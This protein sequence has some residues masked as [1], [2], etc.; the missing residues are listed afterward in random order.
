MS[1]EN[2]KD[3][4]IKAGIGL[5][6][7]HRVGKTTLAQSLS[8][9]LQLPFVKTNTSEVF[10]KWRIEPDV[11]ITFEIRLGIQRHILEAA[12]ELWSREKEA[13]ITD[14]TPL[15]MAAYTLADIQ[16][17]TTLDTKELFDYLDDCFRRTHK[18]FS[19]LIIIPP[20][21]PLTHETGKA[22]LN[23]CYIEHV[24]NLVVGLCHDE[25]IKQK[26]FALQR[27]TLPLNDRVNNIIAFLNG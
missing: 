7:A 18:F 17:A 5:C 3:R 16:G 11:P 2:E 23:E 22:A 1:A 14:R 13:F 21:I 26:V 12:V 6:G 10:R 20:G 19:T 8:D 27:E 4:A 24:H 25:R 15:D 9:S